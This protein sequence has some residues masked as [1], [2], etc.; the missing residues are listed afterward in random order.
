MYEQIRYYKCSQDYTTWLLALDLYNISRNAGRL[1]RVT[2][3]ERV[4]IPNTDVA[5]RRNWVIC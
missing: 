5:Q 2:S 4:L 1:E 3:T